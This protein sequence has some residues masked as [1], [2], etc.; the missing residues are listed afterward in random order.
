MKAVFSFII[1]SGV[2]WANALWAQV[3][4]ITSTNLPLVVINT[5]GQTIQEASKITA[6]MKLIYN[7]T[8]KVNTPADAGNIY[9]GSI[10]IE[11]QG[12][13]P[14]IGKQNSYSFETRTAS[15]DN[16]NV[17]LLGMPTENDWILLANYN[18]KSLVRNALAFQLFRKMGHYAPR[19]Q[20]VEV[21]VNN[22]Y[23]GIYTLTERIKQDI[24]RVNI[25]KL[26]TTDISGDG[27]TGGYIFKVDGL[28]ATDSWQ[29]SF[30][31]YNHPDKLVHYVYEDP[32]AGD[33]VTQQKN[34]LK[35]VVNSFESVLYGTGFDSPTSGYPAWIN[36]NSFFDYFIVNE[37]A[38]NKDA[39]RKDCFYY[40]DKNSKDNKI[41]AGPVWNFEVGFKNLDTDCSSYAATDGSGWAYR[42]ND[43]VGLKSYSNGWMERL[44][45]A[46][47]FKN[48]LYNRYSSL[49]TTFI[50]NSYINNFIDSVKNLVSEAQVRHYSKWKILAT[51]A[52]PDEVDPQPA[53]YQGHI[54]K[55]KNWIQVRMNWLDVNMPGNPLQTDN[56][57]TDFSYRVF[58]NPASNQLFLESSSEIMEYRIF[59]SSG[60]LISA[61]ENLQAFSVRLDISNYTRG[62]YFL[63][64]RTRDNR[65]LNSKISVQ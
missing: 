31:P 34:Y 30:P 55:L 24:G 7:G 38:R 25:S 22:E 11:Y 21:I 50:S 63:Q 1:L 41:H 9:N 14:E 56:K 28:D 44:L 45:E 15:G 65:L 57:Y 12:G 18:D 42:I 10:G 4:G 33:L 47:A 2:I 64:I 5:N 19:T 46:P 27:L 36:Q 43:C 3:P 23:L 51:N 13:T 40:K 39:F 60:A 6:T 48:A 26:K 29:G 37:L 49:R 16:Q 32:A 35:T 54:D 53:T 62:I 59:N 52:G 58:P 17:S 20:T 61:R 8:G